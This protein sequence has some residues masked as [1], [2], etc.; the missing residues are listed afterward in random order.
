MYF[1]LILKGGQLDQLLNS[2]GRK[3]GAMCKLQDFI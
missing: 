2:I 1:H 3:T